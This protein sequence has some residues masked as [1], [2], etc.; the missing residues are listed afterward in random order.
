[1][2]PKVINKPLLKDFIL[3]IFQFIKECQEGSESTDRTLSIAEKERLFTKLVRKQTGQ[4][5]RL[6]WHETEGHR[7]HPH[8]DVERR[9]KGV[10]MDGKT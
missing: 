10:K 1:M 4:D 6:L 5:L 8:K 9:K 3:D 7:E 2:C